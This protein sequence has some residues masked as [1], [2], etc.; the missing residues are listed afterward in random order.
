M[1]KTRI[2][3][4]LDVKGPNVVKGIQL[5]G[6]RVV[7]N[8]SELARKYYNEGADELIYIDIVASLYSRDNLVHII[9]ETIK[10][11]VFI[12]ITVGG[13]IRS[14]EDIDRVLRAGADKV[15]INT[16][17]VKN[18]ELLKEASRVFGSST[19]VLSVEAK[20]VAGGEWEAYVDN[21]REKTGLDVIAWIK[22]GI[23]LGAGEIL[24]TSVDREGTRLGY[25]L[26][27]IHA[28]TSFASVPVVASGGAGKIEHVEQCLEDKNLDG[29]A[30]ASLFHYGELT[31]HELKEK[32]S[33]RY[34]ERIKPNIP[35]EKTVLGGEMDVTVSIVD[36]RLGNLRSVINAFR[37][38]GARPQLVNTPEQIRNSDYLVL[39][40]VGSFGEGMKH[41]KENHLDQ[42]VIEYAKQ[43]KPLLGICLGMQ[44]LMTRSYEFGEHRG[45]NLIAGEVLPFERNTEF[46]KNGYKIPHVGWNNVWRSQNWEETIF[47]PVPDGMG[48][49]FV[50]SFYV[51]PE[52]QIDVLA[53]TDYFGHQFCSV[54]RS[55]NVYGCQFHPEKSGAMGLAILKEFIKIRQGRR[56]TQCLVS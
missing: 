9:E 3:P 30:I 18:P 26:D 4:R 50:H 7:G 54:V 45:L 34:G 38:I 42:A 43:G 16:A 55:G 14:P 41:L 32:L 11:D 5:E 2:I 10:K 28:V 40:G 19:I 44:L 17:A 25:D 46:A 47:T 53:L 49:Y 6:L 1:K 23:D 29:I 35:Y 27:L 36:Y 8:P 22:K 15:A 20:R 24:L 31:V 33:Q 56:S 21:G 39:P 52:N 12:P 48:A 13:G 51:K 37:Q